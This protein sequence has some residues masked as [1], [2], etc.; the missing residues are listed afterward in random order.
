MLEVF[1]VRFCI[2]DE[3]TIDAEQWVI[4]LISSMLYVEQSDTRLTLAIEDIGIEQ[5]LQEIIGV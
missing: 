1:D 4:I 5:S 3:R 2:E